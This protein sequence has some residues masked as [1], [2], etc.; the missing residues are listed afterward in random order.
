MSGLAECLRLLAP[1]LTASVLVSTGALR[2]FASLVMFKF[3]STSVDIYSS[4]N[5]SVSFVGSIFFYAD[6]LK[7]FNSS[8]FFTRMVRSLSTFTLP[9]SVE[10]VRRRLVSIDF[11]G[12]L[13]VSRL[14]SMSFLELSP[15]TEAPSY[16]L[17]TWI[18][19]EEP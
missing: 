15:F 9:I 8:A 12:L 18:D 2:Y 3:F 13:L 10:I 7:E 17:P 5:A 11:L 19:R 4:R 6:I 14:S 1:I 16:L